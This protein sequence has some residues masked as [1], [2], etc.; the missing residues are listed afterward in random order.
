MANK[1]LSESDSARDPEAFG[2]SELVLSGQTTQT[3][4]CNRFFVAQTGALLRIAF[5]EVFD[6]QAP[7]AYR[8]AVAM[9]VGDMKE[10]ATVIVDVL[11]RNGVLEEGFSISFKN[12]QAVANE[13]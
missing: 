5:G 3:L 1:E 2:V 11:G 4:Y 13:E 12:G 6:D 10:L 8:A 9:H 7:P